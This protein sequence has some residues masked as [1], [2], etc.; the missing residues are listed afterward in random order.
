MFEAIKPLS[1]RSAALLAAIVVVGVAAIAGAAMRGGPA[2]TQSRG[3]AGLPAAARGPISA[4]LG[5]QEPGYL[6][7]ELQAR[8]AGQRLDA[9]FSPAGVTIRGAGGRV[10]LDLK[11]YGATELSPVSPAAHANRIVYAH[12]T[13]TETWTNVPLGLEQS[14][15]LS[16]PP[17]SAAG[18]LSLSL[19]LGGDLRPSLSNGTVLLRGPVGSLAYGGLVA[20]D[21]RGRTLPASLSLAAGRLLIH[22]DARSAAYPVTIDPLVQQAELTPPDGVANN[23]FGYAIAANATTIVVGQV[24]DD[25]PAGA[26]DV[27][28]EPAAGWAAATAPTAT[29]SDAS[30]LSFGSAVGIDAAGDT[31]IVGADHTGAVLDGSAYV[32]VKP[33]NGWAT[34]SAPAATLTGSDT[35]DIAF[36]GE[37]VGISSDGTTA[38]V[39]GGGQKIGSNG[40]QG[41]AYV[42]VRPTTGWAGP[43]HQNAELTAT[44]GVAGEELGEAAAISSDGDTVLAGASDSGEAHPG[45]G[46]V[47]AFEKPAAGWTGTVHQSAQLTASD[48]NDGDQLGDSLALAGNV[49]AVGA[50]YRTPVGGV[51]KQGALYV[52]VEPTGGWVNAPQNDELTATDGVSQSLLGDAVAV[53]SDGTTVLG[54]ANSGGASDASGLAYVFKEPASGWPST[55]GTTIAHE[56]QTLTPSNGAPGDG[57]GSAVAIAGQEAAVGAADETVGNNQGEGATY[58]FGYPTP[59]IAI[60]T[61]ASGARYTEG[62]SVKAAYLCSVTGS[63]ISTCTGTVANGAPL[64]TSSLGAHSFTVTATTVDG[65]QATDTVSYTVVRHTVV[66]PPPPVI[67]GVKQSHKR[68]RERR[69]T[70]FTFRLSQPARV[71]LSFAPARGKRHRKPVTLTLSER[72][73][74]DTISFDGRIHRRHLAPGA[75]KVTITATGAGGRSKPHSLKFTIT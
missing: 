50:P 39:G 25:P 20:T 6:V 27:F 14:F 64:P 36:F 52:Y 51:T 45:P 47:Y 21:A 15:R 57:F 5:E 10:R 70:K 30:A 71:T 43:V 24:G 37:T 46:S 32:F 74:K 40:E 17:P 61:P 11:A 18:M 13:I 9:A 65:I 19:A 7:T 8:N 72:A 48:G 59:S 44:G 54:G 1:R 29:L 4:A 49:L 16:S 66:R 58:L 75:Y 2:R 22:V 68:W 63:T 67:S 3:L 28:V 41:A 55:P 31:I 42:F 69:G 35:G 53:S 62:A 23:V 33:P 60:A 56:T 38:V 73:G 26:V 12:P 34:S